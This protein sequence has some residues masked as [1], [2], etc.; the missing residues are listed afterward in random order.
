LLPE[1]HDV[2]EMLGRHF[3]QST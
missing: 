2:L 1:V 3:R